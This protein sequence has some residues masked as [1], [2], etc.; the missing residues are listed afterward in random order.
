MRRTRDGKTTKIEV[1]NA[2]KEVFAA[3]GFAGTSLAMI[4][5]KCDISD[6]LILHHFKSKEN[7]YRQVQE[8][9]AAEYLQVI[10]QAALNEQDPRKIALKT[11]RASFHYWKED[12][13]YYRISLWAYLENQETLIQKETELTAGL[14]EK[15][16]LMQAAGQADGRFSP[17]VLLTMVIGPLHFWIRH[18][19]MFR[20]ALNLPDSPE[21]LDR[22]FEEQFIQLVMKV[23]QPIDDL[24]D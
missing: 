23:Y 11:L 19:E 2:A 5:A 20:R 15:V 6:G 13:S 7:L 4:S 3:H 12:T 22:E 8:Q 16:R 10:S 17:V 1:I 18:R 24:Q 9:L 21:E 14:A